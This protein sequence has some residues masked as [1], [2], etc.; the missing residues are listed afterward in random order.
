MDKNE[1]ETL[2]EG[3]G[4]IARG[5]K[6][7]KAVFTSWSKSAV[8]DKRSPDSQS[9]SDAPDSLRDKTKDW[10]ETY[11]GWL[12]S[13]ACHWGV[14]FERKFADFVI[15]KRWRTNNLKD[16]WQYNGPRTDFDPTQ[17]NIA[18]KEHWRPRKFNCLHE[19]YHNYIEELTQTGE[20]L[21]DH[22]DN[23]TLKWQAVHRGKKSRIYNVLNAKP[24]T[25]K[26]FLSIAKDNHKEF[27][28]LRGST[29]KVI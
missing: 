10:L 18:K 13:R 11:E 9:D 23:D 16:L 21:R 6:K 3:C 8:G 2:A 5:F 26:H 17:E 29:I 15:G 28:P 1:L 4:E 24:I 14:K 22:R 25:W 7:L 27:P 20:L 12:M 19:L